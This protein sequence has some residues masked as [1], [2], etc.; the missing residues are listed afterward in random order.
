M[1]ATV[2][3]GTLTWTITFDRLLRSADLTPIPW[4]SLANLGA[5]VR[6]WSPA[7]PPTASGATVTFTGADGGPS[8]GPD[9]V[10]YNPGIPDLFGRSGL[11]VAAFIQ[12]PLT[13]L[14]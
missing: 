1:A 4:S 6:V 12:F 8:F 5:G 13:V 2:S 7:A 14:P 9:S 11:P 3:T 10:T